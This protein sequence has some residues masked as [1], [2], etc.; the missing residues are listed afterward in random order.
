GRDRLQAVGDAERG[1]D[2]M[3]IAVAT[4][5]ELGAAVDDE[6]ASRRRERLAAHSAA[7]H[8]LAL[9]HLHVVA[10]ALEPPRAGEPRDAPPDDRDRGH[11]RIIPDLQ[12]GEE[13]TKM[14][15]CRPPPTT[16]SCAARAPSR[17]WRRPR[18]PRTSST[19]RPISAT[20]PSRSPTA[21]GCT[22]SRASTRPRRRPRSRRSWAPE[23]PSDR[24]LRGQLDRLEYPRKLP[25]AARSEPK[26]SEVRQDALQLRKNSS[27]SSSPSAAIGTSRAC[28]PPHT[29]RAASTTRSS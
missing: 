20:A 17:S 24:R 19:A 4:R 15:R 28:S 27:C 3:Q 18:I 21:T 12:D 22:A 11:P 6:V 1:G 29:R 26:A 7:G 9:E 13:K 5:H 14:A 25:K 8:R 10:R 2:G 16:S 23:S